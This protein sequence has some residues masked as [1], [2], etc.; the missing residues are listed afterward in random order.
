[1]LVCLKY[2]GIA[3]FLA[4]LAEDSAIVACLHK[5]TVPLGFRH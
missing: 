3:C 4:V 5:S 2:K 1:M